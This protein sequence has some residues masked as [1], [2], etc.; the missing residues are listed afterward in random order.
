MKKIT[1]FRR[2]LTPLQHKKIQPLRGL[3][4]TESLDNQS[5]A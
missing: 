4:P 3:N 1:I 5:A 2:T